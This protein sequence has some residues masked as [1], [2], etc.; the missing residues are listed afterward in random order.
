M[1]TAMVDADLPQPRPDLDWVLPHLAVGGR[2][3][4]DGLAHLAHVLQIRRVIDVR[5]EEQD[6]R[7]ALERFGIKLLHLPTADLRPVSHEHISR[8]VEWIV[9]ARGAGERVLVHCEYGIGRSAL[10]ACCALV[11]MGHEPLSALRSLKAARQKVS[12]SPEQLHAY[13]EWCSRWHTSRGRTCP[14]IP[15]EHLAE[16]AYSHLQ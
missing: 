11:G 13:Q 16:I 6:S 15:W 3:Q 10:L 4:P 1:Q 5:A 7:E 14:D 12:P 9:S 8:G 2:I